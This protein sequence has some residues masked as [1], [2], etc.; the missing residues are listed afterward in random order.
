M[1]LPI[2]IDSVKGFMDPAEGAALH[3]AALACAPLGPCLEIGAYCGK[4]AVYLGTACQA[5]GGVLFSVDH[6]RGS[7]EN[8][9]GWEYH[10]AQLW[11]EAANA[12]DTLPFLRTTLRRA[13]L[14]DVVFP[15]VGRSALIAKAWATPLS[16]L[17]I[18]GGHT[19]E[20]ALGDWRHW[21]PHLM[22]GGTLAIHDVF[23][24]PADGG[25]PPF[26]IYQRALA[27]DLYEE[28][29]AVKSLRVLRRV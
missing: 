17:F 25:R 11:D 23:P 14:E 8:Q 19:M 20:H 13:G 24:D 1:K 22:A 4:S 16:F 15:V 9:P 27:S 28:V 26:E 10:D 21:T 5:A 6:H 3:D 2:D 12:M 18:D 29:A 7:E